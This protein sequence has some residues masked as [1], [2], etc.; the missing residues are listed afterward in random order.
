MV[1][2]GCYAPQPPEGAPCASNGACPEPLVCTRGHCERELIP[3]D[4]P[5]A[6]KPC[7]PIVTVAGV[8]AAPMITAPTLDGNLAE[9][10]TCFVPL[11]RTMGSPSRDLDG[12]QRFLSGRFSIARDATHVYVAVEVNGMAP[13]GDAV[14]PA[15]YENNSVSIYVDADGSFTS[16]QYD[17]DALQ[18]VIDHANRVQAFRFA[19]TRPSVGL[20]SAA[21]TTGTTFVIEAALVSTTFG[22]PSF[23]SA[24]G[25]DIGLEGGD[26]SLQ[27]SEVWWYQAC[28]PPTCGCANGM[29]T[30]YCD[31]RS[32]GRA[33]LAP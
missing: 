28:S 20:A 23:G 1:L 2:I 32:F 22:R 31:A 5:D 16:M 12:S 19:S 3:D 25:F 6:P 33:L 13:L 7:T 9:W 4:P 18:I 24:I 15:V 8:L 11:D 14:P 17:P 10:T 29:V 26:G 30:P 21:K 27:Y